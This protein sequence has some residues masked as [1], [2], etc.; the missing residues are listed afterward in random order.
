MI[1]HISASVISTRTIA[2]T[3]KDKLLA[4]RVAQGFKIQPCMFGQGII[5]RILAMSHKKRGNTYFLEIQKEEG[6]ANC[7]VASPSRRREGTRARS[8]QNG[9]ALD[10]LAASGRIAG[11]DGRSG[12]YYHL[13]GVFWL[14]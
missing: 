12:S 10:A 1:M 3:K 9:L 2:A 13:C 14:V 6:H 5:T 11:R 8:G 7:K 4:G